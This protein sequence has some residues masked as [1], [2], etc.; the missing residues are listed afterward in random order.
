MK[1]RAL[2]RLP[3]PVKPLDLHLNRRTPQHSHHRLDF[4]G[5]DELA[6][7]LGEEYVRSVTSGEHMA[8]DIRDEEVPEEHGG[9]F[10][11]TPA[12]VELAG[13]TDESNPE[14][15]EVSP[16]PEVSVLRTR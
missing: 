14:D 8:D 15:A 5:D 9:P 6:K 11:T 12:S 13:G 16:F 4:A 2:K 1:K 7:E 3:T 10:I